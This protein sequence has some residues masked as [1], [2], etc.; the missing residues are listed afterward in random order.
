MKFTFVHRVWARSLHTPRIYINDGP[1]RKDT[2]AAFLVR[3]S[4]P[5][6]VTPIVRLLSM[7]EKEPPAAI[8]RAFERDE[9]RRRSKKNYH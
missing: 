4:I 8:R 5:P 7:K 6:Q 1:E 3:L 9:S 2:L